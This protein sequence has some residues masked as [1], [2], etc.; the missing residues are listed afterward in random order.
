MPGHRLRPLLVALSILLAPVAQGEELG[1]S[2]DGLLA[3][4]RAHSTRLLAPRLEAEAASARAAAAGALPDPRARIEWM[5]IG[6]GDTRNPGLLPGR[7]G[8][9]RYTLMQDLPWPGKR[10]LE[11]EVAASEAA[12]ADGETAVRWSEL[13]AA[14]GTRY[15]QL[16]FLDRDDALLGDMLDL[17]VSLEQSAQARHAS[18]LAA[19]QDVIRA[20]LE[21]TAL[22]ARRVDLAGERRQ[23][24]AELNVLLGR[25]AQAMLA[26]P[27]DIAALPDALDRERLE[28]GLRR[29]NPRL[30]TDAARVRAAEGTRDRV[31]RERYPDFSL[32][33]TPTQYGNS[34]R[35]WDLMLELDIPLQRKARQARERESEV[36]LAVAQAQREDAAQQLVGELDARFAAFDSARESLALIDSSLLPQAELTLQSA[37][38]GYENGQ[39]DFATLLDAQKQILEARLERNRKAL[40]TRIQLAEIDRLAGV[41]P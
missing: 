41:T 27:A 40:E 2:L 21:R 32:G 5:D 38:A 29:D 11:R 19:Q 39:V 34:I 4:A 6:H 18:G 17:V 37:L 1:A 10:A 20:Q 12:A 7:V 28:R 14:I 26:A 22:R 15:A 8:A 30:R 31:R 25:P 33:L 35:A 24:Q 16:Y 36:R 13:A 23:L 9:M 3:H